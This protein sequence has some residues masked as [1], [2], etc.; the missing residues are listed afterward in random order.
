[1]RF[2]IDVVFL[3]R[4][5]RVVKVVSELKPYRAALG[6]RGAH[7]ALELPA[8]AVARCGIAVGDRLVCEDG[9]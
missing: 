7:S 8:G 5:G 4:N 1:M 9:S 2:A 6:G 3:D